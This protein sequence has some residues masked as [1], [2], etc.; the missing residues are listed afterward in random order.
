MDHIKVLKRALHITWKYRALWLIG[1]LLVLAGGGVTGG[2]SRASGG[3]SSGAGGDGR[4]WGG[5]W[6]DWPYYRDFSDLWREIAP[7]VITVAI[8]VAA[9]IVLALLIGV[10]KVIARYVTRV[11]LI[12]MVN[13]Y[14]ETDE[15]VDF[16]S[17]LRLGWSRSAFRLFLISLIRQKWPDVIRPDRR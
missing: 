6:E 13:Q 12:H 16:W 1:L 5:D 8:I 17:G 15:G 3:A 14:E 4:S 9:L 2:F 7:I 10:I 11:S